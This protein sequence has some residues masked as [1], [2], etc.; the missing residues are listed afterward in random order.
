MFGD[1]LLT[2]LLE[3]LMDHCPT[4]TGAAVGVVD[5][6][7]VDIRASVGEAGTWNAMQLERGTGPLLDA[8]V[9]D[10]VVVADPFDAP[11]LTDVL[12]GSPPSAALMVPNS[13]LQGNGMVTTVYFSGPL[14]PDE[15]QAIGDY[16]PVI[17]YALG[18]VEYCAQAEDRAS[19]LVTMVQNRMAIEQAKGMLMARRDVNSDDAFALLVEHSQARNVKVR[20]IAA[21]LVGLIGSPTEEMSDV[22]DNEASLAAKQLWEQP[23][24]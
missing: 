23:E 20:A 10:Q 24:G 9:R 18:F 2:R 13:F 11:D 6:K 5:G 17:A 16:E 12:P 22:I 1:G 21:A 15:L 7:D 19:G 8:I 4:A 3:S 14:T